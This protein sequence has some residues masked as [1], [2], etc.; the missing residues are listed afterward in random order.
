MDLCPSASLAEAA[1]L[2][3]LIHFLPE[4]QS[5]PVLW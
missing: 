2:H 3:L 4:E 1:L 5:F